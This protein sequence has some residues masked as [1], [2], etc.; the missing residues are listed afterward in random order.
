M[1]ILL[2]LIQYSSGCSHLTSHE[3]PVVYSMLF[4]C[5]YAHIWAHIDDCLA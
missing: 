2:H 4:L 5:I 1:H 3:P